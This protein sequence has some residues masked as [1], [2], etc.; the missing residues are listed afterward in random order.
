M[1]TEIKIPTIEK[2][3]AE[4]ERLERAAELLEQVYVE[5]GPYQNGKILD[6]TWCSIRDFFGFDDS[7]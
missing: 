5:V 3:K 2:L 1:L 4:V 7:E 6:K